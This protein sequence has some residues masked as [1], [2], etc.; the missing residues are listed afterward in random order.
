VPSLLPPH[1]VTHKSSSNIILPVLPVSAEKNGSKM[2]GEE[3]KKYLT[4]DLG[5]LNEADDK[6][7][8]SKFEM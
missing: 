8:E 7:E 4:I 1:T 5:I 6:K 2:S 3:D